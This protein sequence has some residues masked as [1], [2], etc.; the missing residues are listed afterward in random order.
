MWKWARKHHH[1]LMG[2]WPWASTIMIMCNML[3][4][5]ANEHVNITICLWAY[6]YVLTHSSSCAKRWNH[7]QSGM[8]MCKWAWPVC[9]RA[10]CM[11][12]WALPCANWHDHVLTPLAWTCSWANHMNHVLITMIMCKTM[13]PCE[14][15]HVSITI[16]LW[17]YDHV[18]TQSWSCAIWWHHVQMST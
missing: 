10:W 3:K 12:K 1:M 9:K 2:I 11:C 18:L 13:Q 5:C 16:C 15:E 7:V 8:M 4:P 14:H 17:A 6:D